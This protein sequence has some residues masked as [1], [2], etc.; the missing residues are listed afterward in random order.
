MMIC[1]RYGGPKATKSTFSNFPVWVA[2]YGFPE[3]LPR[4]QVGLFTWIL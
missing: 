4:S 3:C 2:M 1:V